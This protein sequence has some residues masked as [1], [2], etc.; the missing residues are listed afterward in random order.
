M[1]HPSHRRPLPT[2]PR[3]SNRSPATIAARPSSAGA[4]R[5]PCSCGRSQSTVA[6]WVAV[7]QKPRKKIP[8]RH[9]Y[10]AFFTA[11]SAAC[12][13]GNGI[14]ILRTAQLSAW[15][16]RPD[17]TAARRPPSPSRWTST[18]RLWVVRIW[19]CSR[20]TPLSAVADPLSPRASPARIAHSSAKLT[21]CPRSVVMRSVH[22]SVR[23]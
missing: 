16:A 20:T 19:A 9:A 2:R 11:I 6:R 8:C 21:A 13:C 1:L 15:P 7:S 5:V 22:V 12:R 23:S 18:A 4:S 3:A 10:A 17:A 14:A